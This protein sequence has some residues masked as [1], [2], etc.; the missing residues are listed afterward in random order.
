MGKSFARLSALSFISIT[1]RFEHA[2][3]HDLESNE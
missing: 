3:A 1:F 2:V